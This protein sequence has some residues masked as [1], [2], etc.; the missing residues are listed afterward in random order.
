MEEAKK[1][2]FI[3]GEYT[4]NLSKSQVFVDQFLSYLL[5]CLTQMF[6]AYFLIASITCFW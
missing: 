6:L 5:K 4:N 2:K 1:M 3:K